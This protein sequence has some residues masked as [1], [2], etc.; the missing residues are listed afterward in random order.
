MPAL[1][2]RGPFVGFRGR[3]YRVGF[4]SEE[5]EEDTEYDGSRRLLSVNVAVM[6]AFALN[7]SESRWYVFLGPKKLA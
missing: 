3:F 4:Y 1:E 5:T 6:P 7:A 2:R